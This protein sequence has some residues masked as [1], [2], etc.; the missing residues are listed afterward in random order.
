MFTVR[1]YKEEDLIACSECL[2]EGFFTCSINQ[3][4][5]LLLCDY[6]QLL[7]E[8]CNFTYVAETEDHQ[9]VG[10][11]GG[12]YKK[13]FNKALATRLE[14]KRHYGQWCKM[15]LKF[16]LRRYRLSYEFQKQFNV[17]LKQL[18]EKDNKLFGLCDLELGVITSKRDYRKGLGSALLTEFLNRAEQDGAE[19]IRLF[20]NTLASWDF[21]EKHGFRKVAEK[22]FKDGSGNRSIV[23]EYRIKELH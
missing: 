3:N 7:T 6:A 18:M 20:T 17:F 1:P 11:I 14:T 22:P 10:F 15:V 12:V 13:N 4:D 23:Y 8:M 5:K 16:F 2:Y 21:Y 19:C 9:V